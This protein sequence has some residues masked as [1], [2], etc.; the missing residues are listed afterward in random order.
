M[1]RQIV[2]CYSDVADSAPEPKPFLPPDPL[3]PSC[4]F[5][6][7]HP[8]GRFRRILGDWHLP[9]ATLIR[10]TCA[11]VRPGRFA[12]HCQP[13]GKGTLVKMERENQAEEK[14]KG[15]K[16]ARRLAGALTRSLPIEP[17]HYRACNPPDPL[18]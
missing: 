17:A 4:R 7:C 13:L 2:G 8:L 12:C 1:K 14:K 11:R 15:K 16:P 18:L 3:V 9:Y 5:T 10:L 6:R